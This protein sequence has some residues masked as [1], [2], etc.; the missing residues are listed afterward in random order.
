MAKKK[1]SPRIAFRLTERE[2]KKIATAAAKC[3][4][5]PG[6]KRGAMFRVA[7]DGFEWYNHH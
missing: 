1:E 7:R 6:E 5:T 4:L 3:G 2:K